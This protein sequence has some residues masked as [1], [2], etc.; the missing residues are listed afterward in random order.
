L[1]L[2]PDDAALATGA[3]ASYCEGVRVR[4]EASGTMLT[5]LAVDASWLVPP[6]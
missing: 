1:A 3:L 4:Y 5:A 2:R 6:S